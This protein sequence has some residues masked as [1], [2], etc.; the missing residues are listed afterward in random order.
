M[1]QLIFLNFLTLPCQW[2]CH[3]Q[4]H[5]FVTQDLFSIDGS[6][7]K[8]S[9]AYRSRLRTD[10]GFANLNTNIAVNLIFLF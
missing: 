10:H 5:T 7:K 3:F 9:R 6:D 4:P 2:C 8:L 1:L